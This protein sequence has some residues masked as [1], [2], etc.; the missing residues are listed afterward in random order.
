[1]P[2]IRLISRT[3]HGFR[4]LGGG[5][6]DAFNFGLQRVNHADYE[7]LAKLDGDLSFGPRYLE[8]MLTRL[9]QTPRLAAVSGK[10]YRQAGDRFVPER[11]IAEQVAGQFKLYRR[12]AYEAIGGFVAHLAWDGI[13]VHQARLK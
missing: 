10:V 9:Q 6:V 13:D 11:H 3:D 2:F 5:V 4:K 7:Y 1:Y 12:E 8:T